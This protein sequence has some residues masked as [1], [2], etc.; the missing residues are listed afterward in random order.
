MKI[1][2]KPGWDVKPVSE[3]RRV[4][5]GHS[6]HGRCQRCLLP[7]RCPRFQELDEF[8]L[9][10]FEQPLPGPALEDLA[11]LQ[12]MIKTPICLDES[13]ETLDSIQRAISMDAGRIVNIKLQRVGGLGGRP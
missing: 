4:F 6:A 11:T 7:G 8:E 10:M 12:S 2:I 13:A 1:K 3:I 5:G 9:T